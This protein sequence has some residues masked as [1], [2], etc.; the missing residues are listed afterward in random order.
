MKKLLSLFAAAV[1]MLGIFP[2]AA[3]ASSVKDTMKIVQMK[4]FTFTDVTQELDAFTL[5]N[6]SPHEVSV[7][8][9]VYD[10]AAKVVLETVH[11]TLAAGSAVTPVKA[12]VYKHLAKHNDLNTYIYRIKTANGLK[13]NLYIAQQMKIVKKNNVDVITYIQ[14]VNTYYHN[15]TVCSFGPHYRDVTP[16]LT[17]L[18]YMFTPIDLT[19]QGRQ[20]FEL[21]ASNMYVIGEVYVDVNGDSVLVTYHN[22][23]DGKGGTTKPVSEH[24]NFFNAYVNVTLPNDVPVKKL[25]NPPTNFAFGRPFSIMNDLGGDANVLMFVR[26]VVNYF[27]FPTP[28]KEF[29]RFWPNT[30][31][32]TALRDGML[33]LMDP[34]MVVMPEGK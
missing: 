19:I 20:T 26:N 25:E 13:K 16:G 11:V 24:L 7:T 27:R 8:I 10:Q 22:Y 21:V 30:P 5:Q 33:M 1:L 18:W 31:E 3:G 2:I 23:Y 6:T 28:T 32:N 29:R 14:H 9:E 12:R 34:V 4:E 17:D 15:N